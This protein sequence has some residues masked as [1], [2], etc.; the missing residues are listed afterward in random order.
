MTA[1]GLGLCGRCGRLR[2]LCRSGR[3]RGRCGWCADAADGLEHAL[4]AAGGGSMDPMAAVRRN[5]HALDRLWRT[6]G[7]DECEEA[8]WSLLES[9]EDLLGKK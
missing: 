2:P 3:H 9:V 6:G 8:A 4:A 5:F 1:S 7:D